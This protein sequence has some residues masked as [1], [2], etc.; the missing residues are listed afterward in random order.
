[1]TF[2]WR[3]LLWILIGWAGL[4]DARS[5][6]APAPDA[7]AV[8]IS[9]QGAAEVSRPGNE[10]WSAVAPGTA[11]FGGDALRTSER[12][13][14]TLRLRDQS[15]LQVAEMSTLRLGA[16]QDTL[17]LQLL[18]G[19]L[20]LF[21]RERTN[22][23]EIETSGV[24]AAILGTE[25]AVGLKPP[26]RVEVVLYHGKVNVRSTDT[27]ATLDSGDALALGAGTA[28][29]RNRILPG[30][31]R[32]IQWL[33]HYPPVLVV[34][35]VS[36][37]FA[38][39]ASWQP[40]LDALRTGD[41]AQA[42]TLLPPLPQ[43]PTPA[44]ALLLA[45][46]CLGTGNVAEAENWLDRV[47]SNPPSEHMASALRRLIELIRHTREGTAPDRRT[48]EWTP[49]SATEWL[50]RSYQMQ[51]AAQWDAAWA[52]AATATR[53]A[54]TSGIA[55]A[56]HAELSFTLGRLGSA[57]ESLRRALASSPASPEA[58]ALQGFVQAADN[59]IRQAENSF[60]QALRRSPS[61]G[62]AW[63][64]RGL[65]RIR[66]GDLLAGRLDLETAAAKE[67]QR[68][69]FRS[70]L[71]KAFADGTRWSRHVQ[72]DFALEEWRLARE[73]DPLDPTP[74]LYAA[75]LAQ[76]QNRVGDA[77]DE[78][79]Q[80][81]ERNDNRALFRSTLGLDQD[82][83]VRRANLASVYAD[84][85]LDAIALREA[86]RAVNDDYANPSAHLFLASAYDLQRDTRR[87]DLR[88]ETPWFSEFLIANLL[89]PVGAGML[90]PTLSHLEYSRLFE[91]DTFS[92]ANATTWSGNGDWNQAVSQRGQN[93]NLA[94]SIDARYESL[95]GDRPFEDAER[96]ALSATSKL[97]A[98][99]AD[100]FLVQ[101]G[102][103][104]A[105]SG[106]VL[107][108]YNPET[109][110]AGLRIEE[111]HE[112]TAFLGWHHTWES[113]DHTLLL[114]SPWNATL[115]YTNPE[116]R[117]PYLFLDTSGGGLRNDAEIPLVDYQSRLQG[118]STELQHLARVG[119]HTIITGMRYQTGSH[120]TRAQLDT[121]QFSNEVAAKSQVTPDFDRF[122]IYAYDRW[123]LT[124]AIQITGGLVYDHLAL[125]RNFRVA[126]LTEGTDS[127]DHWGPKIGLT[128]R[129]WTG[130]M[131]RAAWTR[132]LSGVSL[133]QSQRLEPTQVD[134]FTQA[135]R[136]LIPESIAGSVAGQ[137]LETIGLAWDQELPDLAW[138]T[139]AL[140]Q[141]SSDAERSVGGYV[142]QDGRYLGTTALAED[143]EF[144]E[145]ALSFT[146]GKVIGRH[147]AATLRYRVSDAHF[148]RRTD[149]PEA[150]PDLMGHQRSML[151]QV[152]GALRF[153]HVSG[154]F[155]SLDA[156]WNRQINLEGA[157]VLPG[158]DFWQVNLWM[159]WRFLQRRVEAA[160]GILNLT[161]SDYRL[162]PLNDFKEPY[163]DR[164]VALSLRFEL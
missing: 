4:Q 25:V 126:P 3:H 111:H 127:L 158:D 29:V 116:H 92:F 1:M 79:R 37:E 106:D 99:A 132:S 61:L 87:I 96:F 8:V 98:G 54:P 149:I 32:P 84:A 69:M 105:E 146:F 120:D 90:S 20:Y 30:D 77:I 18:K 108:R 35:E 40:C 36:T 19:F 133:D 6:N 124:S 23:I 13:R 86:T 154:A 125:P 129:P 80:S 73:L 156:T 150:V 88:Y 78:L 52:A 33:L 70:Y 15:L 50:V 74:W 81:I 142:F 21:H 27:E 85:G 152:T 100:D 12:S 28:S 115:Q 49:R 63:L 144:D 110:N 42:L 139:L 102:F 155:A 140:E 60:E 5:E 39:A 72:S 75:I 17:L 118:V 91:R 93:G 101:A 89:A 7:E 59:Q 38:S 44:E 64:G 112:P 48:E 57:R 103:F 128:L 76:Q 117:V 24:N 147:L 141:L 16:R 53:L 137:R 159:G 11:L 46:I 26:N 119:P 135:F 65:C 130:G 153:N 136:G 113:A 114:V 83:A 31:Y 145:R 164:T 161:E 58:W 131:L 56:R 55:W 123:E 104:D 157:S 2:A 138:T 143:L 66:R 109:V 160:V 163:R 148:D 95:V 34:E 122:S 162:H 68:A 134:G 41:R 51:W 10:G 14:V 107:P 121:T 47:G 45:E 22:S 97:Q 9:I 94:W 43:A 82:R 71:G 62:Q 151:H 67:P